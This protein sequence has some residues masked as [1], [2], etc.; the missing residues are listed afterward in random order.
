MGLYGI[1]AASRPSLH[2]RALLA[3]ICVHLIAVYVFWED[4]PKI[5]A[6]AFTD[7]GVAVVNAIAIPL[8]R[9][10]EAR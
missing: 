9:K 2:R 4:D 3:R 10:D 1:F 5:K 6:L 7:L 8:V